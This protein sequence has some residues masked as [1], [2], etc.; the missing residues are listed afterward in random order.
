[1]L[2]L[3]V[4]LEA[5]ILKV[6]QVTPPLPKHR[7]SPQFLQD[8][9]AGRTVFIYLWAGVKESNFFPLC[10]F[11]LAEKIAKWKPEDGTNVWEQSGLLEG[12]IMIYPSLNK[13]GLLDA[14]MYW[15][16]ATVPYY[17][18][19]DFSKYSSIL[20]KVKAFMWNVLYLD[21]IRIGGRTLN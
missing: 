5:S 17:I 21:E 1:M 20:C 19:D 4:L 2:I 18:D 9:N 7:Y 13:N 12:D 3:P 16:N 15:P 10:F 6:F 14:A 11:L 8:M